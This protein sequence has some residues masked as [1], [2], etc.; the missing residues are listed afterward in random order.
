MQQLED[1]R[2]QYEQGLAQFEAERPSAE[3][4]I[5]AGRQQLE[6]SAGQIAALEGILAQIAA[7]EDN[8]ELPEE[9][10]AAAI[11]SIEAGAGMS[12]AQIDGAL[13]A[14]RPAYEQIGRAHV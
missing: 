14:A 3:E 13:A 6:E 9:E 10:K 11:E 8:A 1:G 12:A 4:Q 7:I 2:A 5:A